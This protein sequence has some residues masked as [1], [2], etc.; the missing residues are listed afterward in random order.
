MHNSEL[1]TKRE[2]EVLDLVGQG[3][4]NE[5][6][7]NTLVIEVTTVEQHLNRV[8]IK[9]GVTSRIQAALKANILVYIG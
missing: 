8:F 4:S 9:L 2:W 6:I 5:Q 3:L 7:A 1:L